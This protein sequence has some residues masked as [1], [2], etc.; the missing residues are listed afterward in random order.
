VRVPRFGE[1]WGG[2]KSGDQKRSSGEREKSAV[3]VR[4]VAGGGYEDG[5]G[6]EKPYC[7]DGVGAPRKTQTMR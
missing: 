5:V 3:G 7:S 6:K 2:P 1:M 4:P